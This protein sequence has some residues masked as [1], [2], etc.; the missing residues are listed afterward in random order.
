MDYF[1]WRSEDNAVIEIIRRKIGSKQKGWQ[2]GSISQPEDHNY[3]ICFHLF[4]FILVL[5]FY[6]LLNRLMICMKMLEI[7]LSD[8]GL[9]KWK[10]DQCRDL[11]LT[12]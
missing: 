1:L 8:D 5:F 12:L 10:A 4:L 11:F 9:S 2:S 3:F 6:N 7:K